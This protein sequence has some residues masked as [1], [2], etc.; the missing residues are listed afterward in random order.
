M[1][2]I[3]TLFISDIYKYSRKG[4]W[5]LKLQNSIILLNIEIGK[6]QIFQKLDTKISIRYSVFILFLLRCFYEILFY[7]SLL[8]ERKGGM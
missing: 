1:T 4:A 6:R 2:S 7:L 3:S 5:Y 8:T